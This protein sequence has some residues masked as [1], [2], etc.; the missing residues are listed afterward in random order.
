VTLGSPTVTDNS[1]AHPTVTNDA[2]ALFPLGVTVVTWTARDA[3]GNTATAQ[4]RV[5][6]VEATGPVIIPPPDKTV[7]A[8]GPNGTAV[9]LGT[10][11]VTDNNDPNPIVTNNAPALFPLGLTIVTWTATDKNAKVATAQQ[12]VTLVDT[13]PPTLTPPPAIT[14]TTTNAGGM[15]V[16]LGNPTVTDNGDAHPTVSNDAPSIFPIGVTNVTWTARDATGNTATATQQVTVN[17]LT[18][19][20]IITSIQPS[21]ITSRAR[22]TTIRF[23]VPVR[24]NVQ[25]VIVNSAGATVRTLANS[26]NVRPG[27]YR[28]TW[29]GTDRSSRRVANGQYT[30][31][32][33]GRGTNGSAI[34]T[35]QGTIT[36][37]F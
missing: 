15:A 14:Q 7:E 33:S 17:L 28:T 26:S 34:A 27:A 16:N 2:P 24:A 29:N 36:V 35:A 3:M 12:R 19:A 9:A 20:F 31:V 5:S 1:D 18:Q 30:V 8:A 10:P 21:T 6:V 22:T 32:I 23:T 4:Q 11:T 25:I 37:Q 13:T